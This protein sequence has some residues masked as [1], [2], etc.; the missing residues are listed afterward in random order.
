MEQEGWLDKLF[1]SSQQMV[2]W[3]YYCYRSEPDTEKRDFGIIL[4]FGAFL[5]VSFYHFWG[6][7]WKIETHL[8]AYSSSSQESCLMSSVQLKK[9]IGLFYSLLHRLNPSSC[10]SQ[11][12]LNFLNLCQWQSKSIFMSCLKDRFCKVQ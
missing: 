5:K 7:K 6:G 8:T 12:Q 10:S 3:V 4:T 1:L 2:P 9:D 11:L